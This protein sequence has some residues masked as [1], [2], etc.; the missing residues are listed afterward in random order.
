[1]H[2]YDSLCL[3][4]IMFIITVISER[5][6]KTV[7]FRVFSV[8]IEGAKCSNFNLKGKMLALQQ[9]IQ[10]GTGDAQSG[11]GVEEEWASVSAHL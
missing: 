7:R 11:R 10:A 2:T 4:A 3:Y 8:C 1:M 5:E 6:S 9:R